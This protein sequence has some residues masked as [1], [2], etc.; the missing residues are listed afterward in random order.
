M[1]NLFI[2]LSRW[3]PIFLGILTLIWVRFPLRA[4]L[5]FLLLPLFWVGH[6]FDRGR[7]F[8]ATDLD[9]PLL[10]LSLLT[11]AALLSSPVD[12]SISVPKALGLVLGIGFYYSAIRWWRRAHRLPLLLVGYI[13]LGVLV[14]LLGLF[15]ADW[16]SWNAKYPIL[17][18]LAIHIPSLIPAV[19]G[20]E[21]G[22][23]PNAISGILT[24]FFPFTLYLAFIDP[25]DGY[26]NRHDEGKPSPSEL[27][28]A[29]PLFRIFI[30]FAI[31]VETTWL[32]LS[33]SRGTWLAMAVAGLFLSLRYLL[34]GKRRLSWILPAVFLAGV[35]AYWFGIFSKPLSALNQYAGKEL[36]TTLSDRLVIWGWA[37]QAI[38]E[39]PLAG[40]GLDVFRR[41]APDLYPGELFRGSFDFAHAHNLW[42][43]V[44]VSLGL[45]GMLVYAYIWMLNFA[46]LLRLEAN[47]PRTLSHLARGLLGCWVAFFVFGLADTIPLG[48]KLGLT[49]WIALALG[50]IL[51]DSVYTGVR[52]PISV[53]RVPE[54]KRRE[55][56]DRAT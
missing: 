43:D 29:S 33:Q 8:P 13:S 56:R 9:L 24:L 30:W 22:V 37:L 17:T 31:L 23:Y 45:G 50:Q 20:A 4:P 1:K 14:A 18:N 32:I 19:P 44:G 40:M 12:I 36:S 15:G 41:L 53:D 10:F 39:Y 55:Y 16:S 38:K 6:Y 35:Y 46:A 28:L 25:R 52:F 51:A 3:E 27:F 47:G 5:F 11:L 48:S 34:P 2:P 26:L 49:N 21:R 54:V 7:F 42:L